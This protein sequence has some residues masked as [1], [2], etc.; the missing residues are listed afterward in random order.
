MPSPGKGEIDA[1]VLAGAPNDG[2]LREVSD[3]P[4]EALIKVAGK[5]LVRYPVEALR[6]AASVGRI[7]VVGPKPELEE[8]LAGLGV[9]VVPHGEDILE[10]ALIGSRHL[11]AGPESAPGLVLFA[12]ADTPLITSEIVDG[13]VRRC[14]ELGGEVFYPIIERSVMEERFPDTRRTYATLRDGTFTG[15]NLFLA[16]PTAVEREQATARAL[17]KARKN[18]VRMAQILGLSFILRLVFGLLDV[19]GLEAHVGRTFG[20]EA[21]AVIVPWPEIGIDV[22]KPKDLELVAVLLERERTG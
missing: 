20:L 5:P 8:A 1:V 17:I 11:A 4:W 18:P 6:G 21:R 2:V 12:T 13:L 14:L 3:E 16:D 19:A 7:V 22:D 15:G 10:T 9:E